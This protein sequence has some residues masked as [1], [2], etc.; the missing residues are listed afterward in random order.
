MEVKDIQEVLGRLVEPNG[1]EIELPEAE[2][3]EASSLLEVESL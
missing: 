1:V 2:N 3:F